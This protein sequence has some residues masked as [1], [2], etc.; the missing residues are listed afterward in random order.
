MSFSDLF[1]NSL[2]DSEVKH[3]ESFFLSLAGVES[4]LF[5]IFSFL[6]LSYSIPLLFVSYSW[7]HSFTH[8]P[9]IVTNQAKGKRDLLIHLT[10]NKEGRGKRLP[11]WTW[12]GPASVET[13][14]RYTKEEWD[15][16]VIG[17]INSDSI[18]FWQ[19]NLGESIPCS[20]LLPLF[21]ME[22]GWV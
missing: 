15:F 18:L 2:T 16:P 20:S 13:E 8:S 5:L 11:Y 21:L 6:S 19:W 7:T 10:R 22:L 3:I 17:G 4:L 12:P 14:R 1:L 9:W